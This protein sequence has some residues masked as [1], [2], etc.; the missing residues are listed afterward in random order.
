MDN[1]KIIDTPAEV[2]EK[3]IGKIKPSKKL[4]LKVDIYLA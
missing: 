1:Y 4:L 2:E 3:K